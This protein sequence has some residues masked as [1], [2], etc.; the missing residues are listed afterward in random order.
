MLQKIQPKIMQKLDIRFCMTYPPTY[1][2]LYPIFTNLPTYPKIRYP[3]W[4]APKANI[5]LVLTNWAI[6]DPRISDIC[7]TVA[8][9]KQLV[10]TSKLG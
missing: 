8:I 6:I 2:R 9:S 7:S 4:I 1:I 10:I 5:Y 3:L